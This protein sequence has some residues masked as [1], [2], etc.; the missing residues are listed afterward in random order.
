MY[1][2]HHHFLYQNLGANNSPWDGW[3]TTATFLAVIVA[4]F[5]ERFWKWWTKPVILVEFDKNSDRCFRT[6]IVVPDSFQDQSEINFTDINKQ[7]FR[8]KVLNLGRESARKL[9]AKIEIYN[10]DEGKLADRFEPSTLR[11]ITGHELIDLA[12]SEESYLNLAS[13]VISYKEVNNTEIKYKIRV[14]LSDFLPRGIAWDRRLHVYIFKIIFHAEN[15]S[16]PVVK[17][18]RFTPSTNNGVGNLEEATDW[19]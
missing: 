17:F 6:A 16:Q 14:E 18:F 9:K 2:P 13:E 5:G 1:F 4:L 15:L 12:P 7:Y 8:L 10:V 19:L 11:W 3:I